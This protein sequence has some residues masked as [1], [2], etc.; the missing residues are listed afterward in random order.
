MI[1]RRGRHT[2]RSLEPCKLKMELLTFSDVAIDFSPEEWEC[3]DSAQQDMYR[4]VMLETFGNLVSL[5]FAGSMP[6]LITFLKQNKEPCNVKRQ[7]T[8][9]EYPGHL[10]LV[11]S[12]FQL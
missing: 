4:D 3:L 6:N 8:L 12:C 11:S 1:S 2:R 10:M 9:A 7:E 5:G